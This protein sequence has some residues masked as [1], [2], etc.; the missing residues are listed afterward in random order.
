MPLVFFLA[1]NDPKFQD[2]LDQM[3]KRPKDGG[4]SLDSLVFRLEHENIV[5][6][7]LKQDGPSDKTCDFQEPTYNICSFWMVEALTRVGRHDP[8]KLFQARA[9]FDDILSYANHL[10]L[11][12]QET[13]LN[14]RMLGNFP[15]ALSHLALISAA[16]NLN[17]DL[18]RQ[19]KSKS[20]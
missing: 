19:S 13:A 3:L 6:S 2:S 14:R 11:Y 4:L 18:N 15:Q 1:P 12:S 10:G 8:H 5:S 20:D 7:K 17:R 9:K 16:Y